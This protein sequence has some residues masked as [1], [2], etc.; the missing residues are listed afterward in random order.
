MTKPYTF[1]E[2]LR[3]LMDMKGLTNSDLARICQ[4][5]RS[6]ITRYLSGKYEAKQDVLFRIS[7]SLHVS[8]AWLM[9][10]DC[11]IDPVTNPLD[12]EINELTELFKKLTPAAQELVLAQLRGIVQAQAAQDGHKG[13]E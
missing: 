8:E 13:S 1:A 6:N 11:P 7:S 5:N 10:Y 2:R 4:I 3:M 12:N 9:G